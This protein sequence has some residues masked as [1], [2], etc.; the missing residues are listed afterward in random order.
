MVIEEKTTG[1][2]WEIELRANSVARQAS[3][4]ALV[5]DHSGS[6]ATPVDG[7]RTRMD[8]L[9]AA[10][11]V[12]GLGLTEGDGLSLVAFYGKTAQSLAPMALAGPGGA[13]TTVAQALAQRGPGGRTPKLLPKKGEPCSWARYWWSTT[14]VRFDG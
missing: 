9:Q 14:S 8:L 11:K 5:L 1:G 10:A 6:M 12:F 7:T 3:A 4:V 13:A 2:R